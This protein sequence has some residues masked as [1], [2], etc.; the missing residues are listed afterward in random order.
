[1]KYFAV[2]LFAASMAALAGDPPDPGSKAFA[3]SLVKSRVLR[4]GEEV[5]FTRPGSWLIGNVGHSGFVDGFAAAM[6]G[7][8]VVGSQRV[9]LVVWIDEFD[10]WREGLSIPR[11][12]ITRV[13]VNAWARARYLMLGTDRGT[14]TFA[15]QGEGSSF[16]DQAGTAEAAKLLGATK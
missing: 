8:F 6:P 15:L 11:A 3:E 10:E 13:D 2:L 9:R 16:V 14:Y 7:R 1:M 4:Q 12:E 5:Q